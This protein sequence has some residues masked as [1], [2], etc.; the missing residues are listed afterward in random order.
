MVNGDDGITYY[1]L[2][3]NDHTANN[4]IIWGPNGKG[5]RYRD[6][7]AVNKYSACSVAPG[8]YDAPNGVA[9]WKPGHTVMDWVKFLLTNGYFANEEH[10]GNLAIGWA[11]KLRLEGTLALPAR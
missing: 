6:H 1:V 7:A 10:P 4:S 5:D 9:I 8:Y 3:I 11:N 2:D